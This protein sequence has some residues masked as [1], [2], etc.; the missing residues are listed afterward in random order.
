MVL[1]VERWELGVSKNRE[2]HPKMDGENMKIMQN[3]IKTDD[4]GGG[5]YPYFWKHPAVCFFFFP[6]IGR[7]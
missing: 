6:E 3:P 2:L 7:I 1:D 4:L 5:G